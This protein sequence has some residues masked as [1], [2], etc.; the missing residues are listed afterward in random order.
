MLKEFLEWLERVLPGLFVAFNIGFKVGESGKIKAQNESLK[1][2]LD[3]ALKENE[4]DIKKK[5]DSMS[6]DELIDSVLGNGHGCEK[7][8]SEGKG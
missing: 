8:D 3:L 4:I 7:P 1:A 6:H 5:F 2:S